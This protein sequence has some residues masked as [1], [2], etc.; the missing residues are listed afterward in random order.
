MIAFLVSEEACALRGAWLPV[1]G[2]V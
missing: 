2:S 1:F